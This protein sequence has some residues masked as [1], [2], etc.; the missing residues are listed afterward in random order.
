[1][2]LGFVYAGQGSQTV[3]MGKDFYQA[4]PGVRALFDDI[5]LEFDWK[6]VMWQGPA[7]QLSQTQ[8]TQPCMVAFGAA[9]TDLLARQGIVPQVVAGLSLGEYSAL[10]AAGAMDAKTAVSLV[11]YRGKVMAQT[12]QHMDC[13]MVAVLGLDETA[14]T[15]AVAGVGKVWLANL[16]CPGQIVIGGEA[17]AVDQAAENAKGLGAKRCLPLQ[18]SGPFHT[19]LMDEAS[20]LLAQRLEQVPIG[21]PAIPLI[22]NVTG[23]ILTQDVKEN[24]A[25]QIKSPVRFEQTIRTMEQLGVDTVIEI[26]PGKVLSGFIKKTAPA[27]QTFAVETADDLSAVIAALK[28]AGI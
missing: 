18:V 22:C 3:G 7:E 28:G 16:N 21:T 24:L 13:K 10:Y 2:K 9:V 17:A 25:L 12:T 1:M 15:Q 19:P 27:I 23:Q 14:V 26:G 5:Q 4:D 20:A 11:A 8:Y 6:Q